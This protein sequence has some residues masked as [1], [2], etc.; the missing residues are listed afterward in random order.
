MTSHYVTAFA[1]T[2]YTAKEENPKL[3]AITILVLRKLIFR[4]W[5]DIVLHGGILFYTGLKFLRQ[6]LSMRLVQTF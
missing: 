5:W 1:E 6:P 4:A 2:L 3:E